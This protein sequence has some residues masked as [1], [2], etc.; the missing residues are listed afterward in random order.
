[1]AGTITRVKPAKPTD[2]SGSVPADLRDTLGMIDRTTGAPNHV[3]ELL[4]E[5][6]SGDVVLGF[7]T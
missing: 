4:P 5:S 1:M 2:P 3:Q 6:R 7:R